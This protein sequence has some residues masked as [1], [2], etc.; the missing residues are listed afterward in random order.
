MHPKFKQLFIIF[1]LLLS[2][3]SYADQVIKGFVVYQDR[4]SAKDVSVYIN[5]SSKHTLSNKDGYFELNVNEG[6]HDLII[7][8][9]G[10][11]TI[12]HKIKVT[13]YNSALTFILVKKRVLNFSKTEDKNVWKH[14]LKIFNEAFIGKTAMA[15]GCTITNPKALSFKF[16]PSKGELTATSRTPLLIENKSLGYLISYDLKEFTSSIVSL[17]YDGYIYYKK[18]KGNLSEEKLWSENRELAYKGS[19]IHFIRSL[20]NKNLEK[21]GFFVYQFNRFPNPN[22]PKKTDVKKARETVLK[23]Y[24]FQDS[25]SVIRPSKKAIDSA[26]AVLR[27][28]SL[29]K[30]SDVVYNKKPSYNEMLSLQNEDYHIKFDGYLKIIYTGEGEE[31]RYLQSHFVKSIREAGYQITNLD[32]LT[33]SILINASGAVKEPLNLLMEGYWAFKRIADLLPLDYQMTGD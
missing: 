27:K 7:S 11:E 22:S 15:Q 9:N 12:V 19:R 31:K 23:N 18:L 8:S 20:I 32:L 1:L 28:L 3:S 24:N 30:F 21:Q 25:D 6:Y 17:S 2:A 10:F 13:E 4:T 16:N 26:R 29:P 5:Y 14:H 33:S